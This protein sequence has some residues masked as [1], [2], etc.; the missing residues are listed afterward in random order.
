MK[1]TTS[2]RQ[3]QSALKRWAKWREHGHNAF[4][5]RYGMLKQT[6]RKRK[7]VVLISLDEYANLANLPC[8]YCGGKLPEFGSGIDRKDSSK[9]YTADNCVSCCST[10]N[11]L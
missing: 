9:D 6:A 5:L 2:E 1:L 11:D 7:H 3:R 8:H 10:C 4:I